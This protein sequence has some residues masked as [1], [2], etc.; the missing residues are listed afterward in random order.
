MAG[1]PRLND[2]NL[3]AVCDV[4]GDTGTGLTGTEIGRYLSECNCPDPIPQ[5]TKRH[6]LFA[7]L[8]EKQENDRC[9]NGVLAFVKHVM[10]PVRRVGR[11]DYFETERGKLNAVLAFSG[12]I[13]GE[14][15]H[16]RPV[17]TAQTLTEA[18]AAASALR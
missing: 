16:L 11:K 4:L 7:A 2:A 8:R 9:A 18:E 6:R 17:K 12:L 1:M 3:Q 15:G 10:N 5:M 14:D 13:L